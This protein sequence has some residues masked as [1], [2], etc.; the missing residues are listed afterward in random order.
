M[1]IFNNKYILMAAVFVL[2]F[3][4]NSFVNKFDFIKKDIRQSRRVQSI[5]NAHQC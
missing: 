4:A 3:L 5:N 2:G 1:Q